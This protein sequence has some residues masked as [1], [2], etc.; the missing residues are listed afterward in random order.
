MTPIGRA[1]PIIDFNGFS[2]RTRL[3]HKRV[4]IPM[5]NNEGIEG[6]LFLLLMNLNSHK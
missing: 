5:K 4:T 3:P 1:I 6:D 2:E